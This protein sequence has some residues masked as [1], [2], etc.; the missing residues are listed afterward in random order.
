MLQ[1]LLKRTDRKK[2]WVLKHPVFLAFTPL[3]AFAATVAHA[4]DG[5]AIYDQHCG[6]CHNK[7]PPKFGDK[8][9]WAPRIS[10]GTDAL[11]A[12]AVNGK[13][14]MK[15]QTKAGLTPA[16]IKAAVEYMVAHSK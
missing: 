15:P 7:I 11:V 1:V 2:E 14:M 10:K 9:A 12:S 4:D 3:L 5:K 8:A 16:Q 6:A 13:G